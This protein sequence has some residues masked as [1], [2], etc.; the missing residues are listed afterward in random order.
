M[1]TSG[2]YQ[3]R[4]GPRISRHGF[5]MSPTEPNAVELNDVTHRYGGVEAVSHITLSIPLGSTTAIVGP[6]GVGKSTLLALIAGVRQL[7]SG[8]I[9]ALGGDVATR[10]HRDIMS[11]RMAYMPQGLGRNL[12]P[13]L[14]VHE[15]IDFFGRLFG[16]SRTE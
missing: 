13:S 5:P 15:N 12:Y 4:T 2:S 7:Q 16:Q 14:S 1:R 6:D 8:T 11:A 3:A 10:S 9:R